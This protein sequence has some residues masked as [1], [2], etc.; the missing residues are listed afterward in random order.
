MLQLSG[1][2]ADGTIASVL[3]STEY[4][5]WMREQLAIGASRVGRSDHHR[6]VCFVLFAIDPDSKKA[7]ESVRH[8]TAFY[9][10]AMGANALTDVHGSSAELTD[11]VERGGAE[12]VAGEM[13]ESWLDELIVAGD[14][15]ECAEKIRRYLDAGADAVIIFPTPVERA[16]EIVR[17]AA[18]EVLPRL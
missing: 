12:T 9:L 13:P 16:E 1:E 14:P 5:R 18:K 11:M 8:I 4:V 10:A 6:I 2:I 17:L 3:A 7:K 15:E